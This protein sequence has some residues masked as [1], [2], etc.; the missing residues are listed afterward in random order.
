[1]LMMMTMYGVYSPVIKYFNLC[2]YSH[3]LSFRIKYG[4]VYIC[5]VSVLRGDV[6]HGIL[7]NIILTYYIKNVV[8]KAILLDHQ[9][10]FYI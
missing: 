10:G 3:H 4:C 7:C 5:I 6:S 9:I 2:V 1:M 8:L